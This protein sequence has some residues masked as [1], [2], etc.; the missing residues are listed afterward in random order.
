MY[1]ITKEKV[2]RGNGD[3]EIQEL[4]A[5]INAEDGPINQNLGKYCPEKASHWN[6]EN[7]YRLTD[8]RRGLKY[9]YLNH[10]TMDV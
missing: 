9:E 2:I 5:E 6:A 3:L 4:V 8:D 10:Q 7:F 1:L